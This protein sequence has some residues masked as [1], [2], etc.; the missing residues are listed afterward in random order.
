MPDT[1]EQKVAQ[2]ISSQDL[3]SPVSECRPN[4]LNRKVQREAINP[5]IK[6]GLYL[7]VL[8]RSCTNPIKSLT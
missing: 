5:F 1:I 7:L 6:S 8:G 3:E 2:I 4:Y